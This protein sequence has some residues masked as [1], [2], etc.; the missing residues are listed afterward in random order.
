MK[1]NSL[2]DIL[3]KVNL[4]DVYNKQLKILLKKN[5]LHFDF[6]FYIYLSCIFHILTIFP[7]LFEFFSLKSIPD[8]KIIEQIVY[9]NL[10]GE[11]FFSDNHQQ[12]QSRAAQESTTKNKALKTSK[13][14]A[15]K[16]KKLAETKKIY[17]EKLSQ[18]VS[19][20]LEN[21]IDD[22]VNINGDFVI[23]FVVKKN[24]EVGNVSLL[25]ETD[26]MLFNQKMLEILEQLRKFDPI[27][28]NFPNQKEYKFH[29]PVSID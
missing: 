12:H 15:G 26:N 10:E 22:N 1:R 3:Q 16:K 11:E 4:G 28:T 19:F 13:K 7:I 14:N 23:E 20:V 9:L 17:E 29:I 24:G 21:N 5:L 25:Q 6:R 27:P 8:S 2:N 18:K